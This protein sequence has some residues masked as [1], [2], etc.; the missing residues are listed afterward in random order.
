MLFFPLVQLYPSF[1]QSKI[2][3]LNSG[4]SSKIDNENAISLLDDDHENGGDDDESDLGSGAGVI[5]I[6]LLGFGSLNLMLLYSEKFYKKWQ[7][8]HHSTLEQKMTESDNLASRE[9]SEVQEKRVQTEIFGLDL[10]LLR[11]I[12]KILRYNHY[13]LMIASVPFF[14]IHGLSL[15]NSGEIFGLIG[16]ITALLQLVFVIS[17][18]IIWQKLFPFLKSSSGK[19]IRKF[20]FRFHRSAILLLLVFLIHFIHIASVDD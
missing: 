4:I 6:F 2:N 20:L 19:K 10:A 5:A 18:I 14:F 3:I 17:G 13:I 16:K 7:K 11:K 12:K 9:T 15:W 8:K 1:N